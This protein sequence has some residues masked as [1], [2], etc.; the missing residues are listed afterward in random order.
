M[1][2][3][4]QDAA[5]VRD[6]PQVELGFQVLAVTECSIALERVLQPDRRRCPASGQVVE[7]RGVHPA[8][9][10]LPAAVTPRSTKCCS[11]P[12]CC[13]SCRRWCTP[14]RCWAWSSTASQIP[15]SRQR[16]PLILY[17]ERLC[18]NRPVVDPIGRT[19]RHDIGDIFVANSSSRQWGLTGQAVLCEGALMPRADIRIPLDVEPVFAA[20]IDRVIAGQALTIGDGLIETGCV[21]QAVLEHLGRLQADKLDNKAP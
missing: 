11:M 9:F 3:S 17:T 19:A 20:A 15:S 1:E 7:I 6:Q 16:S 10:T 13:W 5:E 14:T 12:R 4:A 2:A 8:S 21:H 18:T